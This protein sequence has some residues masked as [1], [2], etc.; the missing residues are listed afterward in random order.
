MD[1]NG[2]KS[3][4]FII[5]KDH[6]KLVEVGHDGMKGMFVYAFAPTSPKEDIPDD[7]PTS[8]EGENDKDL[9][10]AIEESLKEIYK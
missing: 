2:E 8:L 3:T 5:D 9:D 1:S 4:Y 6:N 10:A 7:M